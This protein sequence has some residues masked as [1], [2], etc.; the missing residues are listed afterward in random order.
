MLETADRTPETRTLWPG[1][2]AGTP[3]AR[4]ESVFGGSPRSHLKGPE[5]LATGQ[6][7]EGTGACAWVMA[8]ASARDIHSW[9]RGKDG[10]EAAEDGL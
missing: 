8:R 5:V 2:H 4:V 1:G 10:R 9:D 6:V 7:G 3:G